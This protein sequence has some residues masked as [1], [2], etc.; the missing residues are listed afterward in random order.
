[1]ALSKM[2]RKKG[3]RGTNPP[4]IELTDKKPVSMVS[5]I[6]LCEKREDVR[7]KERRRKRRRRRRG[8][9]KEGERVGKREE[10]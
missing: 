7:R 4:M 2:E 5:S 9:E 8:R 3:W 6:L 1:M 10:K